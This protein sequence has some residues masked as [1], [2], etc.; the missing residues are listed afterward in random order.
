MHADAAGEG[1]AAGDSLRARAIELWI[2]NALAVAQPLFAILGPKPPF[3][4]AH[5]IGGADVAL[6]L[7]VLLGA[8]PAGALVLEGL[9]DLASRRFR[10]WVHEGILAALVA[11]IV[12]P[13]L[14]RLAGGREH[15]AVAGALSGAVI[16]VLLHRR[17]ATGRDLL[18]FLAP[19]PLVFAAV[20]LW[21]DGV[22][23][24][25]ARSATGPTLEARNGPPIVFLLLDELPLHVLLD[26]DRRIDADL[27]PSFARLASRSVWFR[28]ATARHTNTIFA[29]PS[30]LTGRRFA[31]WVHKS[32]PNNLFT[33]LAGSHRLVVGEVVTG[34]CP[35]G[36]C[37]P[38]TKGRAAD[39]AM[40]LQDAAI[41]Y[42]HWALPGALK[43]T[44]PPIGARWA[45]F[46]NR[47]DPRER[48]RTFR[49]FAASIRRSERP[50]LYFLHVLL[51]HVPWTGLPSGA[52]YPGGFNHV[53]EMRPDD[54]WPPIIAFQRLMLQTGYLDR[55][56]GE[57]LDHLDATGVFDEA[58]LVVTSDHGVAFQ[59]GHGRRN[60]DDANLRDVLHVPL[61]VKPPRL[62]E[63]RVSDRNVESMDILPTMADAL[64]MALP[65]EVHGQSALDPD[66]PERSEKQA[67]CKNRWWTLEAA[68]PSTWAGLEQKRALLGPDPTW[69][70][71]W[72]I[73]SSPEM[74]GRHLD[75]MTITERSDLSY[76]FVDAEA[77]D[78]VRPASG[79][80]PSYVRGI[81]WAADRGALPDEVVVAVDGVVR[82]VGRVF[83]KRDST[84]YLAV[85]VDPNATGRFALMLPDDAFHY[86]KHRVEAFAVGADRRLERM[87]IDVPPAMSVGLSN[88]P[89]T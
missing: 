47:K 2:L 62:V 31:G 44:L 80:L 56:L 36:V 53:V 23:S 51:P 16:F 71:V 69:E 72:A 82:A 3:F 68:L 77:F 55:L 14:A 18:R 74:I 8:I 20:F 89:D 58:L 27:F 42:A 21:S 67:R 61:F 43:R 41:V 79:E 54:E 11:L 84:V 15:L 60:L 65:F 33:W 9:A 45:D 76:G 85:V 83:G 81:V 25:F 29:V 78:D 5:R 34:V 52:T 86:G 63:G 22:R 10:R 24:V 75:G 7:V 1:P 39:R 66:L 17:W 12:H 13:A 64:G 26:E 38:I 88:W 35:P 49:S 48:E 87:R 50:T 46:A 70:D 28:N 57:L 32:A 40:L 30:L 6:L 4:V 59:A 37:E 73:G 19:M